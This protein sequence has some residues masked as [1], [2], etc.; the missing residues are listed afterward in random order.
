MSKITL[1]IMKYTLF[2]Q[3]PIGYE[4]YMRIY[5][6]SNTTQI[7][8]QTN[9][10]RLDQSCQ[11]NAIEC[12]TISTQFPTYFGIVK[13]IADNRLDDG[14]DQQIWSQ[15]QCEKEDPSDRFIDKSLATINTMLSKAMRHV[16]HPT[17]LFNDTESLR[18][19]LLQ[20]AITISGII[21][22][23]ES[24][25]ISKESIKESTVTETVVTSQ[26][27]Y[28]I[29]PLD[30]SELLKTTQVQFV[31]GNYDIVNTLYAIHNSLNISSPSSYVSVWNLLELNRLSHLLFVYAER[32]ECIAVHMHL[33]D[34]V[35]A[36][37][38][39]GY[40]RFIQTIF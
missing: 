15:Q 13:S 18:L 38:S 12:D 14:D 23:V 30:Q 22:Q 39:S 5:G 1:D 16:L 36:G 27:L 26:E 10:N 34:V 32:I 9:E 19:F 35:L 8:T 37:M 20:S 21:D 29:R 17:T 11:T 6:H 24:S 33:Q 7:S 2:E 28:S 4:F 40:T 31:Y 25:T 3:K